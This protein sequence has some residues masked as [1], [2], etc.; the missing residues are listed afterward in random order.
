[1]TSAGRE[2]NSTH[3]E[4]LLLVRT[5]AQHATVESWIKNI[6]YAYMDEFEHLGAMTMLLCALGRVVPEGTTGGGAQ[7]WNYAVRYFGPTQSV[8]RLQEDILREAREN[9]VQVETLTMSIVDDLT[10]RFPRR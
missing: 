8:G 9:H 5:T 6:H 4:Y 10:G 7:S 1:M 3:G 2:R